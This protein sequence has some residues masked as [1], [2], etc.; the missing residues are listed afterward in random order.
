MQ[1]V[2][3]CG[4]GVPS[5]RNPVSMLW[6]NISNVTMSIMFWY[7]TDRVIT[8]IYK[9]YEKRSYVDNLANLNEMRQIKII[10]EQIYRKYGIFLKTSL[11]Q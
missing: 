11:S 3:G 7:F 5:P 10:S 1:M 8:L 9:F 6:Y 2:R 4:L